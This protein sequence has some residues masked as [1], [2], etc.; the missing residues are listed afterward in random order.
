M[1]TFLSGA[2]FTFF[3]AGLQVVY[4]YVAMKA[5]WDLWRTSGGYGG[6]PTA[7]RELTSG[8]GGR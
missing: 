8:R 5:R 3:T 1:G 2:V 6:T 4:Y 7:E